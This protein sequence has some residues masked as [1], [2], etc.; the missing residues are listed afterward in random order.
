[1]TQTSYF[2]LK[3]IR[4]IIIFSYIWRDF[5]YIKIRKYMKRA[6]VTI[7]L[8][9]FAVLQLLAQRE[10]NYI[11][12]LDCSRSMLTDYKVDGKPLWD[13]TLDYLRT[14]I[15]RQILTSTIN[16]VPFQGS[17]YDVTTC[18]KQDFD[19]KKFYNQVKD[20]PQTLTGTNICAAWDKALTLQ[21]ANK[22]NYLILL[23]DGEDNKQG[24][25]AVCKRIRE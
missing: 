16:I 25:D 2:S 17:V 12:I 1:M 7:L 4:C 6:L 23:T 13:A 9:T 22:D 3:N 11:Y 14:D 8:V 21:D 24:V 19:W 18:K 10:R 15:E 5:L 20:Y